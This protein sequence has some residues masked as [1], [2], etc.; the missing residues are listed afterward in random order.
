MQLA[1]QLSN[2]S[3]M[4]CGSR[5]S[6]CAED[7]G[8]NTPFEMESASDFLPRDVFGGQDQVFAHVGMDLCCVL[9]A[10]PT[11][12][13]LSGRINIVWA[14]SAAPLPQCCTNSTSAICY[15]LAALTPKKGS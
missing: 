3:D 8:T 6:H 14:V 12:H 9:S 5:N 1:Y 7:A 10:P 11:P 2:L 4:S 15:L 13:R